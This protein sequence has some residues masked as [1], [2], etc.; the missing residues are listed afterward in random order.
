[1][2]GNP[3][4]TATGNKYQRE[5]DYASPLRGGLRLVRHYNS[6]PLVRAGVLGRQWRHSYE[7]SVEAFEGT[8]AVARADGKVVF[9]TRSPAGTLGG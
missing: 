1:M 8:A 5:V 9:F 6:Y 4:H 2:Q 7:R 3:I